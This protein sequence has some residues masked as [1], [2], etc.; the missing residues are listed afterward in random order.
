[1]FRTSVRND[2]YIINR[3]TLDIDE[4][5]L[6]ANIIINENELIQIVFSALSTRTEQAFKYHFSDIKSILSRQLS[7]QTHSNNLNN[8]SFV[9][10]DASLRKRDLYIL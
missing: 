3:I 9:N 10:E 2:I 8:K 5:A 6:T 1:M 4:V 7:T